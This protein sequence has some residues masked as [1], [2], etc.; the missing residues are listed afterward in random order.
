MELGKV[1]VTG[2]QTWVVVW[3][4]TKYLTIHVDVEASV[5]LKGTNLDI[6]VKK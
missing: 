6:K 5:S 4:N 3:D 2:G 1:T